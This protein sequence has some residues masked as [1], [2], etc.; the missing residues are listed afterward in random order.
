MKEKKEQARRY[1]SGK[2]RYDLLPPFAINEIVRIFS[3]GSDK[4]TLR[5]KE[6]NVTDSADFNWSKGQ[7][8]THTL[9]SAERHINKFKMGADFDTDYSQELLQK[10]GNVYHIAAAAWN[11]IVLLEFYRTHSELDDRRF[12]YLNTKKIALDIDEVLCDWVKAWTDYFGQPVPKWWRF[13][14]NI[15]DKFDK[16]KND[17][18]FWLN[19]PPKINPDE[20]PF[21][22]C[23]YIT[24]RC[25]PK[26]WT[27]EWLQKHGFAASP[28]INLELGQSK[29]DAIKS[30]ECTCFVDD[31]YDTFCEINSANIGCV[32][33][34]MDA[35]HNER[36][37]V[38]YRRIKSLKELVF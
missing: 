36:F 18:G 26:E 4:Y 12:G 35:P 30:C 14:R 25:I 37:D 32:C 38:G 20:I 7:K 17:K 23:C 22:P 27:E 24:S 19:I 34:L 10:W 33:Y 9:A 21:E 5:D 16:M 11:L 15:G 31:N 8:W 13:D 1:N 6:G 28:V 29:L 3:I 2:L